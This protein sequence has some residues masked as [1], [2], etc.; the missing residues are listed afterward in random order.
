MEYIYMYTYIYI[1][2]IHIHTRHI[3][4]VYKRTELA[5][6]QLA[7]IHSYFAGGPDIFRSTGESHLLRIS[8]VWWTLCGDGGV[9]MLGFFQVLLENGK[10]EVLQ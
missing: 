7:R 2:I 6:Q 8:K 4:M 1:H 3:T 9:A 10:T 5:V